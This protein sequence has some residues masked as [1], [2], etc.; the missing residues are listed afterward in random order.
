MSAAESCHANELTETVN[1]DGGGNFLGNSQYSYDILNRLS[2]TGTSSYTYSPGSNKRMAAYWSSGT[3]AQAAFHI[4]DPN[5]RKIG[6]YT[7]TATAPWSRA[8]FQ[9][10]LSKDIWYLGSKR[11]DMSED[12]VGSN[13]DQTQYYPWGQ[14]Q[15]GQQPSETQGFGT[16]V[17]DG[18]SGLYYADQRYYNPAWGRFLTPD[19]SNADISFANPT[20]WNRYAYSNGDPINQNDP[21]G[22]DPQ[23]YSGVQDGS[24]PNAESSCDS[25]EASQPQDSGAVFSVTV[26][27]P[28]ADPAA[29]NTWDTFI[30]NTSNVVT[31]IQNNPFAQI[32]ASAVFI[33]SGFLS[34]NEGEVDEGVSS[35]EEGGSALL[36]AAE[37]QVSPWAGEITASVTDSAT[38]MYRVWGGMSQEV[39][40]WLTP[41]MP[42]SQAQAISSLSLPPGN[43][44]E[45]FS[46]VEVPAGTYLQSGTASAM[47]GGVGGG[48]QVLLLQRIPTSCY[49][50]GCELP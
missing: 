2:A 48:Q 40:L 19:P 28:S 32:G 22:L 13:W 10:G 25:S 37:S 15:A 1:Y 34:G 5:G 43:T 35:A 7:Y 24:C 39:G 41:N 23:N 44:A 6:E 30:T 20:T 3:S 16:Y 31:A 29:Q 38:T 26:D 21:S 49:G 46:I 4:Y 42:T 11:V 47:F 36:S 18:G 14:V 45:F 50:S 33:V 12:Q 27:L 17:L 8:Q 9:A